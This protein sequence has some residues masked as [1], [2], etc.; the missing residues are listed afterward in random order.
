MLLTYGPMSSGN[1]KI[2]LYF[3]TFLDIDMVQVV[4]II[5]RWKQGPVYPV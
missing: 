2:Y 3:Q 1:L 5:P 4:E